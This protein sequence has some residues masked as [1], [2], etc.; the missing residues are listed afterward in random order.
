[1]ESRDVNVRV[2]RATDAHALVHLLEELGYPTPEDVV[3]SRLQK[4]SWEGETVLVADIDGEAVGFATVH[5]TPVLHRPR[6]VGRVTAL[7]VSS[8]VRGKGVGRAIIGA[9][10]RLLAE[11][12]CGVIEITSNNLRTDAHSFYLHLGYQETSRR[13]KRDLPQT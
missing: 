2:A 1:M 13:F 4:L 11:R 3:V 9:A 8:R 10:E 6:P 12:G 7:V 5:V